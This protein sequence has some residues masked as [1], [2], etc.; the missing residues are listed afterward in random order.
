MHYMYTD[1]EAKM[2]NNLGPFLNKIREVHKVGGNWKSW[3]K[4]K[5][6]YVPKKRCIGKVL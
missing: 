6:S 4:I 5:K 1:G 3:K 2:V